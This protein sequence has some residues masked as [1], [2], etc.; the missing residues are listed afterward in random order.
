MAFVYR[1]PTFRAETLTLS[2]VIG[3]DPKFRER[4]AARPAQLAQTTQRIAALKQKLDRGEISAQELVNEAFRPVTEAAENGSFERTRRF[5]T[6]ALRYPTAALSDGSFISET[7]RVLRPTDKPYDP[8]AVKTIQ[9]QGRTLRVESMFTRF[10]P[11]DNGTY[12]AL[13]DDTSY[14]RPQAG[15]L[16]SAFV[17]LRH[18]EVNFTPQTTNTEYRQAA[19]E[20]RRAEIRNLRIQRKVKGRLSTDILKGSSFR[21]RA[22]GRNVSL[23][24][25]GLG[26]PTGAAGAQVPKA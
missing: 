20:R 15:L 23:R 26:I 6:A 14:R 8:A 5:P 9:F 3:L 18:P 21:R 17:D 16:P 25:T 19:Q 11:D 24:D 1:G 13:L 10:V 7:T 4:P 22:G 12:G 2:Q